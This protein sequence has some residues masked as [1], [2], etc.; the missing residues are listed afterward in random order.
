[1]DNA[2]RRKALTQVDNTRLPHRA[3]VLNIN[4]LS[5]R[6]RDLEDALKG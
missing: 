5:Y 2:R 1:M 6:L 4:G 3:H